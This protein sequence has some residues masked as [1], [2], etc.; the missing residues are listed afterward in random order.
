M[1]TVF[2]DKLRKLTEPEYFRF[3][4][5]PRARIRQYWYI[6]K[7]QKSGH[8]RI[9]FLVCSVPMWR[10]QSLYERLQKDPRFSVSIAYYPTHRL[11]ANSQLENERRDLCDFFLKKKIPLLDLS[12]EDSPGHVLRQSL[13]PDI[14][15]YPQPYNHL[16]WN[17]LDNQFFGDK[18]VCYI[19]YGT[20]VS[21]CPW[22]DQ[23]LLNNTAWRIFCHSNSRKQQAAAVLFNHGRNIKVTGDPFYDLFKRPTDH[24]AWKEQKW[25]KKRVI[26]APHHSVH[27][28]DLFHHNS[29]MWL[30]ETMLKLADIY[31]DKIQFSFKPHPLL[32]KSLCEIPEWGEKRTKEYYRIWRDGENTQLDLGSY[33][34]LFK[35]SDAMI[36]DSASFTAEYLL[37]R[38]PVLF[39]TKELPFIMNQS[40]SLGKEALSAHYIC[41]SE[42]GVVDFIENTVLG[43]KDQLKNIRTSFFQK[44]FSSIERQSAAENIFFEL[45][46][47][48]GFDK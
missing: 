13:N 37:T 31:Q 1:S 48:L 5:I 25:K 19:P 17:D 2:I 4:L 10:S 32:F 35:G 47:D 22:L 42:L 8:A 11:T 41:D 16:F 43:G 33:I 27:D 12:K 39:A 38:N 30:H 26:W 21:Q 9:V 46:T 6:H 44:H 14:I 23:G 24:T 40:N 18:L 7:I 28:K 34:D 20:L 36:H 45:I 15:F 29:F 3:F